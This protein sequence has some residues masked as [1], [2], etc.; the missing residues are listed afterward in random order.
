MRAM[1]KGAVTFGLVNIP[2]ALYPA[3]RKEGVK[4]RMLRKSDLS[5]INYK[6]VAEADGKEVPWDQVAK[7]YEYE[8]GKFVVL[9]DED[10]KRVDGEASQTIH[11]IDFVELGEIDPIHFDTPYY[12]EP[13]KSGHK[14]YLLL[15]E[16]LEQTGKIGIAKVVLKTKEHLAA[17]KPNGTFLLL[18][19]MHFAD[20]I[21]P[22]EGLQGPKDEK[23]DK[24]EAEMARTLVESMTEAWNPKKYKDDYSIGL[25]QMID[26]KLKAGT[27][28]A[29][30]KAA[31]R[32]TA[33]AGANVINLLD[34]LQK[35]LD[36][37]KGPA[38]KKKARG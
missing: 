24:R 29:K 14:A 38:R 23:P 9:E 32:T 2:V 21:V 10:F 16:V 5:P 35:S 11:I 20:D 6:R 25:L 33:A 3:V 15:R 13:Q 19:L 34:V 1:W 7:G 26:Q 27:K 8:K 4:F 12:L 18:Q 31:A 28:G 17:L 30:G 37:A 22:V 36:E